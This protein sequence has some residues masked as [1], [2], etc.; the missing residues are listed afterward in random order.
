ML[1]KKHRV[2]KDKEFR[3]IFQK[4]KSAFSGPLGIKCA[5]NE[6]DF[7]RFG[8]AVSLK[9]SKKAVKRNKLKRQIHEIL[10]LNIKN[11]KDGYDCVVMTKPGILDLDYSELEKKIME[12]LRKLKIL[13]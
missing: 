7:S 13:K 8:V 4:G 11:I 2:K 9:I 10:R 5:P 3:R 12:I 6:L 1:A